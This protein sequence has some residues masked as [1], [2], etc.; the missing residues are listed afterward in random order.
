MYIFGGMPLDGSIVKNVL[1][2]SSCGLEDTKIELPY[3]MAG[4]SCVENK[5][6]ITLCGSFY[7]LMKTNCTRFDGESFK[8]ITSTP[9]G[10]VMG[11]MAAFNMAPVVLG[12]QGVYDAIDTGSVHLFQPV[13]DKG[14]WTGLAAMPEPMRLFSTL[15]VKSAV[16][17]TDSDQLWVFGGYVAKLTKSV[18]TSYFYTEDDSWKKGP[19]LLT[20]RS[21]HRSIFYFEN[22]LHIGGTGSLQVEKWDSLKSTKPQK[23]NSVL[24]LTD[25][26]DWPEIFQVSED[27]CK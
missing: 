9:E 20:P 27:F 10:H 24:T 19:K 5:G 8:N 17:S 4:H 22:I 14:T 12:G 25:Y 3:A 13:S 6:E 2:L 21:G 15:V 7:D 18:D 11:A 23:T 16:N 26:T 1:K